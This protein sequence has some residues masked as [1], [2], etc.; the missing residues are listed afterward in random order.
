MRTQG[1]GNIHVE[2]SGAGDAIPEVFARRA[3]M[4][5]PD[6][7]LVVVKSGHFIPLGQPEAMATNLAEFFG[8]RSPETFLPAAAQA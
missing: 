6:A 1:E 5:I 8:R 3:S 2:H 4:L 7:R